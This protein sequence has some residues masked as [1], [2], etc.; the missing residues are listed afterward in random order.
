MITEARL[1]EDIKAAGLDW[2]T[3]LR[4]PAIKALLNNGAWQLTLFDQRDMASITSP[5]FPRE[6]LVVCRNADFAAERTR[7]REDLL[8]A[9]EKDLPRI[10]TAAHRKRDPL[11]STA[12]I[13]LAVGGVLNT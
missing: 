10:K 11:R 1:T 7:K 13:A 3:A 9:T 2:I 12:A 5:D 8:A 6:R 4:A